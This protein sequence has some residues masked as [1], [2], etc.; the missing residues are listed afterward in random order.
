MASI[1]ILIAGFYFLIFSPFDQSISPNMILLYFLKKGK[2]WP[3]FHFGALW[4]PPPSLGPFSSNI[5]FKIDRRLGRNGNFFKIMG[6]KI[7]IL[8][9]L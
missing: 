5:I 1:M 9:I 8:V 2:V 3:V 6:G 4:F 7:N